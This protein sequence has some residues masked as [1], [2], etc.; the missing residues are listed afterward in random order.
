MIASWQPDV[1][2]SA[3]AGIW[4]AGRLGS[5]SVTLST[6]SAAGMAGSFSFMLEPIAAPA[7]NTLSAKGTFDVGPIS[8]VIC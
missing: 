7:T 6:V 5:G 2:T 4:E 3:R 1:R 8:G